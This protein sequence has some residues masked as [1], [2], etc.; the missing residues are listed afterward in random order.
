[1]KRFPLLILVFSIIISNSV[2]AA[3]SDNFLPVHRCDS[4]SGTYFPSAGALKAQCE[5]EPHFNDCYVDNEYVHTNSFI[6][7][8]F[9]TRHAVSLKKNTDNS[10]CNEYRYDEFSCVAEF[11]FSNSIGQ[12]IWE[13]SCPPGTSYNQQFNYCEP[14]SLPVPTNN[15]TPSTNCGGNFYFPSAGAVEDYCNNFQGFKGCYVNTTTFNTRGSISN[16]VYDEFTNEMRELNNNALCGVSGY[17]YR[18][19]QCNGGYYFTNLPNP[20]FPEQRSPTC[21]L[22]PTCDAGQ[23]FDEV[24]QTCV[25]NP[26]NNGFNPQQCP[27]YDATNPINVATGNKVQLETDYTG[28]GTYPLSLQRIYNSSESI[29]STNIGQHWRHSYDRAIHE[30][31]TDN[32]EV[33]RQDGRI[34]RFNH[35]ANEWTSDADVTERLIELVDSQSQRIG[36]EYLDNND[37]KETYDTEGKLVSMTNR[38][39]FVQTLTYTLS[40]AENGDDN[41]DTLDSVTNHFGRTIVFSYDT[42]GRIVS[43]ID[44]DGAVY[45]YDYDSTTGNL[46]EVIYPDDGPAANPKRIYHYDDANYPHALTRITDEN[47]DPFATWT[48]DSE[49]RATSSEHANGADRVDINY[50]GANGTT[51]VTDSLGRNQTYGF[52]TQFGV[53]KVSQI[54]GDPCSS[55]GGQ[56]QATGYDANGFVNS[57]TDFNGNVTTYINNSRGLET[58]R[59]EAVGTPEERTITTEWHPDFRLPTKITEAGLRETSMTYNTTGQVLTRSVKDILTGETRTTTYTYDTNGLVDT[60]DGPRTDVNDIVD[61]DYDASG[62]LIKLTNEIGNVT[63]ITQH[64]DNGRPTAMTDMNDNTITMTYHPRGWLRTRTIVGDTTTYGYDNTGQ[65]T[66]ITF[67]SGRTLTYGYDDAQRLTSITDHQGNSITYTLD[68][69]GNRTKEETK[70]PGG[71]LTRKLEREYDSLSRLKRIIGS[72]TPSWDNDYTYDDNGNQLT[73]TDGKNA[74]TTHTYDALNRLK[75]STD[76]LAGVTTYSYD[77]LDHLT[78]VTDPRLLTTSYEYNAFGD[79][80]KQT[81]PDTGITTMTYDL[82][83]NRITSTDARGIQTTYEYDA[84]NNLL[85]RLHPGSETALHMTYIPGQNSYHQGINSHGRVFSASTGTNYANNREFPKNTYEYDEKGNV[86][87]DHFSLSLFRQKTLYSYDQDSNLVQITY[88]TGRIIDY[89]LDVLGRV[90]SITST[91]DGVTETIA[92][93][94]QYYPFGPVKSYDAGNGMTVTRARDTDYRVTNVSAVGTV[95]PF[96]TTYFD[97]TYS[98]DLNSNID[99]IQDN[100]LSTLTVTP[101]YDALD[102]LDTYQDI[103]GTSDFDYDAVGNRTQRVDGATTSYA[104]DTASNRLD[105]ETTNAV[106]DSYTY[107]AVG[108]LIDDG[109]NTYHYDETSRLREVKQNGTSLVIYNYDAYGRR[110]TEKKPQDPRKNITFLYDLENRLIAEV[111]GLAQ[112]IRE[113]VYLADIPIALYS[114]E[115]NMPD[116]VLQVDAVADS[117]NTLSMQINLETE[118]VTLHSNVIGTVSGSMDT[119]E[120]IP[121][122]FPEYWTVGWTYPQYSYG[123]YYLDFM[124]TFGPDKAVVANPSL[125]FFQGLG[126][127]EFNNN[128]CGQGHFHVMYDPANWEFFSTDAVHLLTRLG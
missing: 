16:G 43:M 49:G 39:G 7:K 107:D 111:G 19:Y 10:S 37:N 6:A 64:D 24:T 50:Q 126:C 65:L 117:G 53:V 30:I 47:G 70:D 25:D 42:A 71:V 82:A 116:D 83:G 26:K 23:E 85:K 88:P 74:T 57:R 62:N 3:D 20:Q 80:T 40:V 18:Q 119:I 75:T 78:S 108:N 76:R 69:M 8:G 34:I 89:T 68:A 112:P 33:Q 102:R 110:V 60:V 17:R 22:I 127:Y 11:R 14:N 104:I 124:I 51:I 21:K 101:T 2:I 91:L 36:W 35:N 125:T 12:C 1:M 95:P 105:S 32:V 5:S 27:I 31:D 44:P 15:F 38:A 77:A 94:I 45:Q 92:S 128:R 97:K 109:Q 59:T 72:A 79:L 115:A 84:A 28:T 41:P 56:N 52:E 66:T 93:N 55:C 46:T 81:S 123:S 48:Y 29:R 13:E 122:L 54:S 96:T 118:V 113:Y 100:V 86:I 61:Y 9:R 106:T 98:Y 99:L 114:H 87:V 73:E 120:E 90:S 4:Y 58:S 63:T 67:P 103:S 121:G